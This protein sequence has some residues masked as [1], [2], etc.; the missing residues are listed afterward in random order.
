MGLTAPEQTLLEIVA[1]F[2]PVPFGKARSSFVG[3]EVV[4]ES[5]RHLELTLIYRKA[6]KALLD[7]ELLQLGDGSDATIRPDATISLTDAGREV[8]DGS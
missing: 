1:A 3:P 2:E 7:K 4:G 8:I 6:L 5:K